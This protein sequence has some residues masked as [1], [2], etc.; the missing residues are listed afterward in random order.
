MHNV[1]S[2][3]CLID[4]FDK[5][6]IKKINKKKDKI[7]FKGPFSK[8]IRKFNNSIRNLLQVMRN[9]KILSDYYLIKI[10]KNIPV[11]AGFGGGASNAATILNYLINKKIKK[12]YT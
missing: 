5:I 6:F 2:Y 7:F 8:N 3:F 12:K 11:F 1:Q 10:H 9:N 4:L